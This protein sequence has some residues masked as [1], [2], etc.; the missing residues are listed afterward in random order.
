MLVAWWGK[1]SWAEKSGIVIFFGGRLSQQTKKGVSF[2][3]T[4][5]LDIAHPIG[6]ILAEG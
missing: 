2:K 6:R 5:Q 3:F 4:L 1:D